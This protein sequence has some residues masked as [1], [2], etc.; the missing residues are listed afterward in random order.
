M[1]KQSTL[2]L[3]TGVLLVVISGLLLFSYQVRQTEIAV[4][5]T[6]GRFTDSHEKP[7]FYWRLPW[8]V[9][10]VYKFENRLQ[11]FEKKFEQTTTRDS[12]PILVTVYA[13]WK[14]SKA[15]VFLER[16]DNGDVLKAEGAI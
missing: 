16:F 12:R 6:F 2:S 13:G 10:K 4:V 11:T 9:Q 8:P 1:L 3:L 15:Q 5:T 7:G 14:I